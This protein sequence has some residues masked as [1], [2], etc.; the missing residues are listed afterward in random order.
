MSSSATQEPPPKRQKRLIGGSDRITLD[1]GGTIFVA[2][3]STLTAN[4]SYFASLL[5][6]NWMSDSDNNEVEIFL[7]QDPVAFGKLLAYMRRGVIR[8]HDIDADLLALAEFLGVERLLLAVKIV[9]YQKLGVGPDL[10]NASAEEV[11]AAFDREHGGIMKAI[12][13]GALPSSLTCDHNA[14]KDYE[15]LNFEG[16]PSS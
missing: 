3:A 12:S 8:V 7:D 1:V 14:Q 2:A 16:Q 5:S 4:C 13:L 11:A 6:D 10:S 15:V 9:S